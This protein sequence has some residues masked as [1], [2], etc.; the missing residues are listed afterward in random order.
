MAGEKW[1]MKV[2]RFQKADRVH[3]LVNIFLPKWC[4]RF[5]QKNGNK[6]LC[7][8][9][10]VFFLFFCSILMPFSYSQNERDDLA[11]SHQTDGYLEED[12]ERICAER[13]IGAPPF[14]KGEILWN[15]LE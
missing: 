15:I 4:Y 6:G 7:E 11:L 1:S 2:F 12:I 14:T 8:I 9:K 13:G 5:T 10:M 3:L